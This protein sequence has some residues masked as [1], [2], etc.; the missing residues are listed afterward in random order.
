MSTVGA[1]GLGTQRVLAAADVVLGSQPP[2]AASSPWWPP[3]SPSVFSA[4]RQVLQKGRARR[5][6]GFSS[7]RSLAADPCA[8]TPTSPSAA[9]ACG[10]VP[11]YSLTVNGASLCV[12]SARVPTVMVMVIV[13][14]LQG[15]CFS[16]TTVLKRCLLWFRSRNSQPYVHATPSGTMGRS[17]RAV[18]FCP[19][20][21]EE[22][23][24]G[25]GV[26]REPQVNSSRMEERN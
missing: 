13:L 9:S 2:H 10:A 22:R 4:R 5:S 12:C 3:A 8:Q 20:P 11:N 1:M 19:S 18:G 17:R 15:V 26:C 23:G 7:P 21:A 16:N 25:H 14:L 24:W 6:S